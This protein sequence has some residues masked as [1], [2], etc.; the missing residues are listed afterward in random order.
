MLRPIEAMRVLEPL[1]P[2]PSLGAAYD[3]LSLLALYGGDY[4]AAAE[5]GQR[6]VECAGDD[7]VILANAL[8]S[9]G[10]ALLLRD[11]PDAVDE[12]MR[13]LEVAREHGLEQEIARAHND[14]AIGGV[15]HR[16]HALA[17]AHIAAG[18]GHCADHDLDLWTLSMLGL[19]VRS[20]LNQGRY[21]E[22]SE[23]AISSPGS[24]AT[25]PRRGSRGCSCWPPSARGGA[26]PASARRSSRRRGSG[27]P[28]TT[29]TGSGR[30]RSLAPRRPGWPATR[31]MSTS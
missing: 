15:I 18:L 16:A 19:K 17:D 30:W 14:L 25:R 3:S 20:E 22:A 23:I 31:S 13:G 10:T 4:D 6:A 12:L 7:A 2:S 24:C 26:T 29:S 1:G 11:G 21:D 8:I 5:W 27:S 9:T 28:R